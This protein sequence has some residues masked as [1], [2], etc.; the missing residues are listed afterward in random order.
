LTLKE[1]AA[2]PMQRTVLGKGLSCKPQHPTFIEAGNI[3]VLI[4]KGVWGW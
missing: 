1:G 2:R 4:L 3:S